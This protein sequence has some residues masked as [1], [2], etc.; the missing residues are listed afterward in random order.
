MQAVC[1]PASPAGPPTRWGLVPALPPMRSSRPSRSR[2][3]TS[4]AGSGARRPCHQT[5]REDDQLGR[6]IALRE[7][8]ARAAKEIVWFPSCGPVPPRLPEDADPDGVMDCCMGVAEGDRVADA[9]KIER[10]GGLSRGERR[11][12]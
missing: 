3:P 2:P 5:S 8:R 7:K 10:R 6:D 12:L 4:A 9:V 11:T 1:S